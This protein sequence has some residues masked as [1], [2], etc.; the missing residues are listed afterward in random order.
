M[1]KLLPLVDL[2]VIFDNSTEMGHTLVGVGH[3]SFMHWV[4]PVPEW[5]S[6]LT[7]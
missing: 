5:A 6:G 1:E 7:K 4:E 2:V 3:T